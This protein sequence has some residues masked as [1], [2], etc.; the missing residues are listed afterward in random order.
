[1]KANVNDSVYKGIVISDHALLL[2]NYTVKAATKGPTIW[3]LSL[4]WLHDNE[5]LKFVGTHIDVYFKVNTTQTSAS[6]RW[7]AFKA[8]T[9]GQMIS[10]TSSI[11][12]KK[13]LKLTELEKDIKELEIEINHNDTKEIRQRLASLR[14]QYNELSTN[15]ALYSI[16]YDQ[17][18]REG[19]AVKLLASHLKSM[20][21]ER[22]IL[23]IKSEE[24]TEATNP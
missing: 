22:S 18:E 12:N 8:N 11:S 23:E 7:E 5:F 1:M 17:G 20:Q 3:R 19:G 14:A 13:H 24:G 9:R 21:N 2:I 10:Y 6:T 15:K 4:R 16:T